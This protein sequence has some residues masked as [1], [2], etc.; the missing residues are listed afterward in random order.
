MKA[1]EPR[2]HGL[3][4]IA[5]NRNPAVFEKGDLTGKTMMFGGIFQYDPVQIRN[6]FCTRH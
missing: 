1:I 3:P 2:E 4:K 6:F 5:Q